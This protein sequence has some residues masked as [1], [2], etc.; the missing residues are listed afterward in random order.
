MVYI[1]PPVMSVLPLSSLSPIVLPF[2]VGSSSLVQVGHALFLRVPV[3]RGGH[4][5]QARPSG[6][7][8][9]IFRIGAGGE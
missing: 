1:S 5:T 2:S 9:R 6:F 7:F 3:C 8:P 4:L